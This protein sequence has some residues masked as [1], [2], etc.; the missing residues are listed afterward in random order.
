MAH[1]RTWFS[2]LGLEEVVQGLEFLS[3][4]LQAL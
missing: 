4:L 3:W 1:V 2:G